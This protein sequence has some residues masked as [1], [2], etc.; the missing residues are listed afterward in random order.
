MEG[1]FSLLKATL[2]TAP[3]L[4][5]PSVV[6]FLTPHAGRL[7][8]SRRRQAVCLW[9][10]HL[11]GC[12]APPPCKHPELGSALGEHGRRDPRPEGE[13]GDDGRG[14]FRFWSVLCFV[15]FFF[16]YYYR[17]P[18]A[19]VDSSTHNPAS[20]SAAEGSPGADRAPGPGCR[21]SG[22][23]GPVTSSD[24]RGRGEGNPGHPDV[25]PAGPSSQLLPE[26][27]VN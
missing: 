24:L 16:Y 21:P 20:C 27:F 11:P 13:L 26:P 19:V 5:A 25:F 9:H 14:W 15:A 2:A 17:S 18:V 10:C 7:H 4:P 6:R 12:L 8:N 22:G 3:S 23:R 1:A